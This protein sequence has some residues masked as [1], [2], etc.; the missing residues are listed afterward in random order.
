M[1]DAFGLRH[2]FFLPLW[3]RAA[4]VILTLGW[5]GFEIIGGS[6][7]WAMLFGGIG[8]SAASEFFIA[9]DPENYRDP[10]DKSG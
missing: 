8:L 4:V 6:E 1:K 2:P 10:P 3:R 7:L 5:A 9:F